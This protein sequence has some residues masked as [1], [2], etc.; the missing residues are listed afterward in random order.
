MERRVCVCGCVWACVGVCGC[1]CGCVCVGV[2]VWVSVCVRRVSVSVS[3]SV[4]GLCGGVCIVRYVHA[5]F[6]TC[7]LLIFGWVG[8]MACV[9][10]IC[11]T[12]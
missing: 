4:R 8:L 1:G 12:L 5:V 7:N 9:I 6:V 10:M 2:C 11:H 3:L